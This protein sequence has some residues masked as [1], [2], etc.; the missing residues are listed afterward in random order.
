MDLSKQ[1]FT[2]VKLSVLQLYQSIA[3][4][5]W[6]QMH[7]NTHP[8]F[9]EYLLDRSTEKF[10]EGKEAKFEIIR[11][12]VDSP[13]SMDIFGRPFYMKL[14]QYVNEGPFFVQ[15]QAQVAMEGSS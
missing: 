8:G 10:K 13:T 4:Q 2:D 1:P 9:N 15:A 6:G 12:L 3:H 11:I 14:K 7:M 5:P